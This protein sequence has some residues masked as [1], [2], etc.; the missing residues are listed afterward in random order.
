MAKQVAESKA[1]NLGTVATALLALLFGFTAWLVVRQRD[2]TQILLRIP[3][4]PANMSDTMEVKLEPTELPVLFTYPKSAEGYLRPQYYGIELDLEAAVR[5]L[6]PGADVTDTE[7]I[8]VEDVKASEPVPVTVVAAM[9]PQGN[10]ITWTLRLRTAEVPIEPDISGTPED[11]YVW[12]RDNLFLEPKT[13]QVALTAALEEK[14]RSGLPLPALRTEPIDITGKSQL[15]I[16]DVEI[17]YPLA[18]GMRPVPNSPV[19][20]VVVT[21]PFEEIVT[22]RLVTGVPVRYVPLLANRVAKVEPNLIEVQV[23]GPRSVVERLN[24]TDIIV[25]LR[26]VEEEIEQPQEVEILV[27]IP[28]SKRSGKILNVSHETKKV[29]VRITSNG[30]NPLIDGTD[31]AF[32][33]AESERVSDPIPAPTPFPAVTPSPTPIPTPTPTPIVATPGPT[34]SPSPTATPTP[35]PTPEPTPMADDE[36]TTDTLDIA[37]ED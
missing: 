18:E 34:P 9:L 2:N 7:R 3:I 35:T 15:T 6:S 13:V 21:I 1:I 23:S 30:S 16:E 29:L 36:T 27:T 12:R 26:E 33:D 10:R 22:Q 37:E 19:S 25:S 20:R 5:R 32:D 17:V 4:Q 14:M 11:G 31:G 28:E 8:S 24:P